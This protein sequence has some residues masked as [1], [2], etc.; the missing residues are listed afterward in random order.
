MNS[1][2][3]SQFDAS[4][5]ALPKSTPPSI[6]W[7]HGPQT[8]PGPALAKHPHRCKAIIRWH[9]AYVAGNYAVNGVW[10]PASGYS[11][12][13]RTSIHTAKLVLFEPIRIDNRVF[14]EGPIERGQYEEIRFVLGRHVSRRGVCH[15]VR[16]I[17]H[18]HTGTEDR[19]RD[20][21]GQPDR[22]R[23]AHERTG[24]D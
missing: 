2:V 9:K 16:R 15:G 1:R 13:P 19:D 6:A 21:D 20:D 14:R 4:A 23:G 10:P 7:L 8:K 11:E 5:S 22:H 3:D 17:Q 18:L 12:V 24:G